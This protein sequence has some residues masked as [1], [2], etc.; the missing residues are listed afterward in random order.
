MTV[1]LYF[2]LYTPNQTELVKA[3][4][5]ITREQNIA[6]IPKEISEAFKRPIDGLS[7]DEVL[8]L[9]DVDEAHQAF[10]FSLEFL[11]EEI[12]TLNLYQD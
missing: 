6:N 12:L 1:F 3:I 4:A 8:R 10:F 5:R 7:W 9:Q 2:K 11:L